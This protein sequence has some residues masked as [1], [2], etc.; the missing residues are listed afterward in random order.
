MIR[1]QAHIVSKAG[2]VYKVEARA[3]GV[4][5]AF[6]FDIMAKSDTEAAM[7]AIRRV[8]RFD[9]ASRQTARND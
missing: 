4:P 5:A 8:E 7:E 9:E 3:E 2:D 6:T 1:V